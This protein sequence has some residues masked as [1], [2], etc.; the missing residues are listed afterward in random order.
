MEIFLI[1]NK[2]SFCVCLLFKWSGVC[3]YNSTNSF[4]TRLTGYVQTTPN[5]EA[6]LT[7]AIADVGPVS[8]AIYASNDFQHYSGGVFTDTTC[9]FGKVNHAVTLVGY[10]TDSTTGKD[11]YILKN[12]WGT[13]W[14]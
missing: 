12:Q 10:G 11:Y 4:N 7:Q 6:A 1:L 13:S 2:H 9:P 8:V 3:K 5:N 14:G